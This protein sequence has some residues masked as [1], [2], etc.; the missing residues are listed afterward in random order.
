MRNAVAI[1]VMLLIIMCGCAPRYTEA[2]WLKRMP[3]PKTLDEGL[4][5]AT[6]KTKLAESEA[7]IGRD[8]RMFTAK[9]IAMGGSGL[10][11]FIILAG[12]FLAQKM[13]VVGGLVG[14]L[15]CLYGVFFISVDMLYPKIFAYSGGGLSL[16]LG[17]ALFIIV[18][19]IMKQLV[20]TTET[21]KNELAK[22][23]KEARDK[24]FGDNGV[25]NNVIQDVTTAKMVSK[26]RSG[27][28]KNI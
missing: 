16:L 19:R 2:E 6:L 21:T 8:N 24:L 13:L 11:V 27:I 1:A 5:Q 10:C 25:V 28:K 12:M 7:K 3:P 26:L 9:L 4:A 22:A 23:S 14:L 15:S 17:A 18:W 20:W